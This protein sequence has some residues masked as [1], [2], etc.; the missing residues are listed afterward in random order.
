MT[1]E[2]RIGGLLQNVP[3]IELPDLEAFQ[4]FPAN[5]EERKESR[6]AAQTNVRTQTWLL[7]PRKGGR[8]RIP[9]LSLAYFEPVS[10]V[11]RTAKTSPLRIDVRGTPKEMADKLSAPSDDPDQLKLRSIKPDVDLAYRGNVG[12]PAVWFFGVLAGAPL[13][14]LLLLGLDRARSQHHRTASSRAAKGAA[15]G[16]QTALNQA[17][18]IAP[19]AGY[20][21]VSKA[22][23]DFLEVRFERP[24]KGLT[25][26]QM[27]S[28]L[29]ALG[30]SDSAFAALAELLETCDFA[31]FAGEDAADLA[32]SV[33][34]GSR[35]VAQ[36]DAEGAK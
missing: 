2:T 3:P 31:R 18:R 21:A 33:Q 6:G 28:E 34:E 1:V 35:L 14:F 20:A 5:T 8:L 27:G 9:A 36:I 19:K 15:K 22:M 11:Y 7:R 10:G 24:F 17:K 25:R 13:A 12:S 30:V 16:A 32:A 4:V 29:R 23:N 26:E